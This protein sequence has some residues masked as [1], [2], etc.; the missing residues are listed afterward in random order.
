MPVL[1]AATAPKISPIS[2]V[3]TMREDERERR[4]PAERQALA[5]R[6]PARPA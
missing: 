5:T 1:R 2:V 6:R 4:V 3:I